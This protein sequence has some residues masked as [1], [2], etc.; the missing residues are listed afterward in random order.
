MSANVLPLCCYISGS[1]DKNYVHILSLK[2]TF[3]RSLGGINEWRGLHGERARAACARA[4]PS[5]KSQC[6]AGH[7]V[8][9]SCFKRERR[10]VFRTNVINLTGL[11]SRRNGD[12]AE[13]QSGMY[14]CICVWWGG[15]PEC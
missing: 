7:F 5:W 9:P 13:I 11:V 1:P 4:I 8:A 12:G 3:P 15:A 10:V 6:A 2:V 14:E